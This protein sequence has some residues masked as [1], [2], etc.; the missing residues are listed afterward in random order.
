MPSSSPRTVVA[1]VVL[2]DDLERPSRLLAARRTQPPST[3]GGWEFPGGKVEPGEEPAAAA[4][5][6]VREEL[7]VRVRL[8]E[9]VGGAWPLSG[10][11]VMHL[12]WAVALPGEAEPQPL[13]DHDLL[14][15][16]TAAE[17]RDVAWLAPDLPIVEHLLQLTWSLPT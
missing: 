4:V 8:G 5:R 2:V 9:R 11:A 3:A 6:E 1:A 12:W 17:L 15:W 16:L 13:E 10:T 14:R 7:G